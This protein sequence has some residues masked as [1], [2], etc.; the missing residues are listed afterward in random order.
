MTA[1]NTKPINIH[2]VYCPWE[3]IDPHDRVLHHEFKRLREEEPDKLKQILTQLSEEEMEEVYYNHAIWARDEQLVD[4]S[5]PH[6]ITQYLAGRGWTNKM[7]SCNY[8]R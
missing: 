8:A 1:I 7:S 2:N 4:F 5:D 3:D 6:V